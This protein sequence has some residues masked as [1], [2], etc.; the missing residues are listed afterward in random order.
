M[1]R[2]AHVG[3]TK[4][5][6]ID[7]EIVE[8]AFRGDRYLYRLRIWRSKGGQAIVLTSQVPG[9]APPGWLRSRLANL[10]FRAYLVFP[11]EGMLYFEHERTR[12]GHRVAQL[13]FSSIGLGLR[14]HLVEPV[15]RFLRWDEFCSL[16]GYEVTH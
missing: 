14:R 7:D 2:P 5:H 4:N 12:D 16:V 6:L 3:G 10:A 15:E 13:A 8:I 9:G 11:P 1:F